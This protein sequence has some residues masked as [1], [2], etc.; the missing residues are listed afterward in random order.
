LGFAF[1]VMLFFFLFL[2][3]FDAPKTKTPNTRTQCLPRALVSRNNSG[4]CPGHEDPRVRESGLGSSRKRTK[5]EETWSSSLWCSVTRQHTSFTSP[6]V[7]CGR[8]AGRH[9]PEREERV[10]SSPWTHCSRAAPPRDA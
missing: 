10:T 9:A 1:P 2:C 8:Q 6:L 7:H 4:V 3:F 5:K